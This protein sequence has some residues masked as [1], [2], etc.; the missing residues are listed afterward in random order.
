V[1]PLGFSLYPRYGKL[2]AERIL[3]RI[4]GHEGWILMS[5]FHDICNH[6]IQT[7]YRGGHGLRINIFRVPCLV[8]IVPKIV[9]DFLQ[10]LTDLSR[11]EWNVEC[12]VWCLPPKMESTF[13]F[14][15][16]VEN[17]AT[18]SARLVLPMGVAPETILEF[19]LFEYRLKFSCT[20]FVIL[21][22][23]KMILPYIFL[24]GARP[25]LS[26]G[27]ALEAMMGCLQP[28]IASK[29]NFFR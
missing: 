4:L 22:L 10:F 13:Y 2:L 11:W 9:G 6:G 7:C 27:V 14:F 19:Y 5:Y 20:S 21:F 28:I 29:L 23:Y 8:L 18:S 12:I 17:F 3:V 15:V 1:R 16:V 24:S 26:M 25:A